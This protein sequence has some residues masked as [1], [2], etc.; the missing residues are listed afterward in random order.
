M[1]KLSLSSLLPSLAVASTITVWAIAFPAIKLA[2]IEMHPLPLA[3]VR[4]AMATCFAAIWLLWK[5]PALMPIADLM[6]SVACGVLGA[7]GYS[8]LLNLGQVTVS[9]GAA[10][11]LIKTES[12]WMAI[13]AVLMLKETFNIWA[14]A[15]TLIGFGGIGLIANA[16]PGGIALGG[17]A[18]FVLAAAICSAIGFVLQRKLVQQYGALHVASIMLIAAALTLSPWLPTAV[19]EMRSASA[20]TV[21]WVVFLG[22]FPTAVGQI[23]WSY[24]LG[25]FGAAR[26]GNFLYLVAPLATL[27]AWLMYGE[28]VSIFTIAGGI[29]VL[30]GVI[31]VNTRGRGVVKQL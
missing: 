6:T 1:A 26:A 2:L 21:S 18:A 15:G 17:G 31:L 10:S 8:V 29:L 16:Q 23:C 5:R 24:A 4:Y 25:H 28:V 22:V 19:S 27:L 7:A 3:S 11:F 20:T 30:C 13:L 12:I 14:W 9:A